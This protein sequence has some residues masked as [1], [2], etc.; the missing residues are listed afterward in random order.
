MFIFFIFYTRISIIKP[1]FKS[2]GLF[3]LVNVAK[4]Y[5]LSQQKKSSINRANNNLL[6]ITIRTNG[7]IISAIKQPSFEKWSIFSLTRNVWHKNCTFNQNLS[8]YCLLSQLTSSKIL[9]AVM[10]IFEIY[11]VIILDTNTSIVAYSVEMPFIFHAHTIFCCAIALLVLSVVLKVSFEP[12]RRVMTEI[13][14]SN[15][16]MVLKMYYYLVGFCMHINERAVV[17]LKDSQVFLF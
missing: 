3:F 4:S 11:H 1:Y 15:W 13:K 12:T 5:W 14:L 16:N 6:D 9:I 10:G 17:S 2:L 8:I 7:I